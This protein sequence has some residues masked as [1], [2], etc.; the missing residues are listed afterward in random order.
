M[1]LITL[2]DTRFCEVKTAAELDEVIRDIFALPLLGRGDEMPKTLNV[3][4]S[5]ESVKQASTILSLQSSGIRIVWQ[6]I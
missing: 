6:K 2:I 5:D 4:Y 3:S 1:G